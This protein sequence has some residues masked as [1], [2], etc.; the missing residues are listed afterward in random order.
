MMKIRVASRSTGT[1]SRGGEFERQRIIV[2]HHLAVVVVFGRNADAV[3][4]ASSVDG[5]VR[6]LDDNGHFV[7]NDGRTNWPEDAVAASFF[8]GV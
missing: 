6:F 8:G 4:F 2:V 7:F 1:L 3:A 5:F